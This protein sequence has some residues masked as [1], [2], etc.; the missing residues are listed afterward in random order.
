ME[1]ENTA[2]FTRHHILIV[3]DSPTQ[4]KLLEQMLA[5]QGYRVLCARNGSDALETIRSARPDLVISDILMPEMD[6]FELCRRVRQMPEAGQLPIILL[7]HLNDPADVLHSLEV[8]AD[9]FVSKPYSRKLLLSRIR[10][11]LEGE[12]LCRQGEA[13]GEVSVGYRGRQYRVHADCAHTLE[14][15]LATYEMAAEKNQELLGAQA[16]LSKLNRELEQ[17]VL[18]RTAALTQETA[19]RL[20]ALEELRKK[21]EVLMQ[22]SRQAAMGEMIGNIAHQWR[23]PLNAVGLLVQDLTLSY[24]YGNF[25]R[26]YLESSTGKIMQMIRHMSQTIDDFRNFFTPDKEKTEFHLE[27]VLRRTLALVDGSLNDK[28]IIIELEAGEVPPVT[29][30]PNEFSQVLLNI[31]NNAM[32]AFCERKVRAPRVKV[33]LSSHDKKAVVTIADNAG[34]IPDGV[35]GRI[36]EPYFTTKEQGKGT[37][38]GLFMAK[39]I[40]EKSM[41]GSLT[42]R[43]TGEGAEFRIEV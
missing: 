38:I 24:E 20:Q 6:G 26:E 3:D 10:A 19:E 9:Y 15:L 33:T 25:T 37:G 8:G 7:T 30:H 23:Q 31:I 17:R 41:N 1:I 4:A 43:N 2:A 22:Q 42:V 13:E 16:L 21:D 29:G 12:R 18:E 35:I 32:D 40:V 14:L 11:V 28:G 5:E 27:K 36:F 39:N 34:G